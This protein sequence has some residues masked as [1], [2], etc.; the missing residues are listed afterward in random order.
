M[1]DYETPALDDHR[2]Q[3]GSRAIGAC[4]ILF[5]LL[6]I[7]VR[8]AQFVYGRSLWMDELLLVRNLTERGF[9]GLFEPLDYGQFAPIG[10]LL[11]CKAAVELLGDSEQ[12]YRLV[13]LLSSLGALVFF[14][15]LIRRLASPLGA[16]IG[17]GFFAC[18]PHLIFYAN[19]FKQYSTDL[20]AVTLV[21]WLVLWLWR[22][23]TSAVRW[24]VLGVVGLLLSWCSHPVIFAL[25]GA[26]VVVTLDQAWRRRWLAAGA[27]VVMGLLWAGHFVALYLLFYDYGSESEI[28]NTYWAGQFMPRPIASME[29]FRWLIG[30]MYEVI[31][32]QPGRGGAGLHVDRIG[33]L[34]AGLIGVACLGL[35]RGSPRVLGLLVVPLAFLVLAAGVQA[36]PIQSRLVLFAAA[37]TLALAG[38]GG[39]MIAEALAKANRPLASGF[40]VIVLVLP[41]LYAVHKTL[42]PA[43]FEE[44]RGILEILAEKRTPEQAIFVADGS[45]TAFEYYHT[46][47]GIDEMGIVHYQKTEPDVLSVVYGQVDQIVALGEVW[48]ITFH[49]HGSQGIHDITLLELE[50][51]RRGE[52][53]DQI[54]IDR[55]SATLY[56]FP[57]DDREHT[58]QQSSD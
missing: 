47:V 22:R 52:K 25:G 41:A 51:N 26:A 43:V 30:A 18:L 45:T 12:A 42:K 55:S 49:G 10:F 44:A 34:L 7:V 21:L 14:A 11:L 5:V 33:G 28:L 4:F 29:T 46:R 15:L 35:L 57:P 17:V 13:A 38:I 16:L 27:G 32:A 24:V 58:P 2:A 56:R 37:I 23:E 31:P 40:V 36:Y 8:V 54:M 48:V 50:L 39:G 20:F 6:G 1:S 3:R 9:A 53:I 19:E